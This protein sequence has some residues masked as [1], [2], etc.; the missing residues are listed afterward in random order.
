MS[1]PTG[2]PTPSRRRLAAVA[3]PLLLVAHLGLLA[4]RSVE[5]VGWVVE[6]VAGA[7]LPLACVG[8]DDDR[9]P[10]PAVG[11]TVE[12]T[13]RAAPW[14]LAGRLTCLRVALVTRAL[15]AQ[16]GVDV[17]VRFGVLRGGETFEAH[18]W[19]VSD[20]RVVAGAVENLD[21][22]AVLEADA[23]AAAFG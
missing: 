16:F 4:G 11:R 18:A 20:G 14:P 8:V 19:V 21:A 23:G 15:Y 2:R 22:Y 5:R 7:C 3:A 12:R 6:L 1:R 13:A 9:T 17:D 10:I